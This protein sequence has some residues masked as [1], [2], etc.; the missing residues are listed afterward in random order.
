MDFKV[1]DKVK[2]EGIIIDNDDNPVYPLTVGFKCGAVLFSITKN[3]RLY[4]DKE[5]YVDLIERPKTKVKKY[6]VLY[7]FNENLFV[8]Q[9]YYKDLKDFNNVIKA[10]MA[11]QLLE[12]TEKEFEE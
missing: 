1:G 8:S 12:A 2:I 10:D 5:I 6:R 9:E 7:E 3:G 4:F 11:L